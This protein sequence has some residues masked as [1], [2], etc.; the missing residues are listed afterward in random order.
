MRAPSKNPLHHFSPL[1]GQLVQNCC[2][3]QP[4]L[5]YNEYN[6]YDFIRVAY[7][8]FQK[9]HPGMGIWEE[10]PEKNKVWYGVEK[11]PIET[12]FTIKLQFSFFL[13][14]FGEQVTRIVESE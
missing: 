6:L 14:F 4:R 3:L 9:G 12:V 5:K 11:P 7:Y 10:E 1:S 8:T 13:D 2:M